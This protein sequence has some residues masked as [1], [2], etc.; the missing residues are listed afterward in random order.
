MAEIDVKIAAVNQTKLAT[1]VVR[2]LAA[3]RGTGS[4]PSVD[5]VD[6]LFDS[7]GGYP[8]HQAVMIES[9]GNMRVAF[10]DATFLPRGVDF[11]VFA[12]RHFTGADVVAL[13]TEDSES[14]IIPLAKADLR[15]PGLFPRVPPIIVFPV[16]EPAFVITERV[17]ED[18]PFLPFCRN[19]AFA[20]GVPR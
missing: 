11:P 12:V 5:T 15:N 2:A 6:V 4:D 17:G 1:P 20:Y 10:S 14:G 7:P 9:R 16:R 19:A 3:L 13:I 18:N 8:W